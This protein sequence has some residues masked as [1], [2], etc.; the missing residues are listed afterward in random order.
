MR[1]SP[2]ILLI[3]NEFSRDVEPCCEW[4]LRDSCVSLQGP[5]IF[6]PGGVGS[7][8]N[9]SGS[10]KK[11][12]A[13]FFH[14]INERCQELRPGIVLHVFSAVVILLIV[15]TFP[16]PAYAQNN[17][18]VH[19]RPRIDVTEV[20]GKGALSGT[21]N[22][23][24]RPFK[25]DADLVL[26]PVTVTDSYNRVVTGLEKNNFAV[27]EDKKKERIQSFSSEDAPVSIG[28]IFDMS[29]SMSDKLEKAREAVVQFA[30]SANPQ[31]EF[32]LIGFS[33]RPEL[34]SG[35]TSRVEDLQS[36]LIQTTAKGQTALLDAIY[37][38][39]TE[40]H[41]AKH[42]RRAL[43]IISDG[44]DN[45]SRYTEGEVKSM[46][47]EA[48][49]Q[50]FGIGIF[51]YAARTDEEREGPE[52]LSE[53]TEATGGRTFALD[54]INDLPDVAA[55]IGIQLRNEYVVGYVP[56]PK[57]TDGKWH[58]IKVKL[59]PPKGLPPLSVYAKK[60]YYAPGE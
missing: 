17:D 36:N 45:H 24:T 22:T 23:H 12:D 46:V 9:V 26:V 49:V 14:H 19:I 33:D 50:I 31:D 16:R 56:A 60:G 40:M 15:A 25:A 59:I 52:L 27:F 32:F 20:G 18:D 29:G 42:Q 3:S 11:P 28:I 8:C 6:G 2:L 48:D 53:I 7:R 41:S 10:G 4:L 54:N 57:P 51:D 47:E 1:R 44:G 55:K 21:L 35:F 58:K 13:E 5:P 37:L 38:G 43:L 39:I 30:Q 34:I